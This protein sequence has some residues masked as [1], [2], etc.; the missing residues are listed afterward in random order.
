[1]D[2]PVLL[3]GAFG[4]V[5]TAILDRLGEKYNWR[6]LDS[7]PPADQVPYDTI[8]G[9]ITDPETVEEAV[10]GVSAVIHLAG[11][12]RSTA[13]WNSVLSNNIDGTYNVFEKAVEAGV[14]RIA[15]AS[16]NHVVGHYET[17][18][19]P[20]IYREESS[21]VLDGLELPRPGNLYGVSK[22]C[23]EFLGRYFHDEYGIRVV[24]IRIGN[25]T[26][27]H[28]PPDYERGQA[29][30]LSHRDCA[31]LFDRSL[32][33]EYDFAIVYGISNNDQRYYSLE[34]ARRILGYEPVDN[35]AEH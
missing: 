6:L 9:D 13:S 24:C 32:Q 23:G 29:M 17:D 27:H 35:S 33:A 12:P 34:A 3:T 20:E 31:H 28:P 21:V 30:W 26:E 1:M 11:D 16:S 10:N 14:E 7:R 18:R 8:I 15:F 4:Q 19:K 22:A 25:L 2:E 5:G